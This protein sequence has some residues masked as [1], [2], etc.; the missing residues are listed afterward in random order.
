MFPLRCTSLSDIGAV[1]MWCIGPLGIG[2]ERCVG[3][4]TFAVLWF[5]AWPLG[6]WQ[7]GGFTGVAF[8]TG[9]LA[10]VLELVD[11]FLNVSLIFLIWPSWR[12]SHLTCFFLFLLPFSVRETFSSFSRRFIAFTLQCFGHVDIGGALVRCISRMDVSS[13]LVLL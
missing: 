8:V 6:H 7:F 11:C 10:D 5:V 12:W 1:L 2:I 13:E 3:L 4:S 9:T